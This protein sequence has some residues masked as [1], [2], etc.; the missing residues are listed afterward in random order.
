MSTAYIKFLM[1]N[2]IYNDCCCNVDCFV[3]C[4][5]I[6]N[7]LFRVGKVP[8]NLFSQINLKTGQMRISDAYLCGVG[9]AMP[10]LHGVLQIL[11]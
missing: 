2:T 1:L 4:G 9:A 7:V 11:V 8:T 6:K 5:G 10:L 3:A